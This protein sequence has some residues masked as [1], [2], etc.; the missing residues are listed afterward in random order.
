[1]PAELIALLFLWLLPVGALVVSARLAP[2]WVG[3][4]TGIA[5]GTIISPAFLGLYGLYFVNPIVGLIGLLAFPLAMLH[6]AP[7]YDL[8]VLLG[9]VPPRT[10]VVG[11]QRLYIELLSGGVWAIVY[12]VLGWLIDFLRARKRRLRLPVNA[13]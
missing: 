4:V 10:V 8:A 13:A 1:M 3:R 12:G 11:R 2:T 6:G 5:L 9:V 7:G